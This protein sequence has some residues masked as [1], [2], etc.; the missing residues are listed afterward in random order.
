M[1]LV[2]R[3][4]K[5]QER[6]THRELLRQRGYYYQLYANQFREEQMRASWE[7]AAGEA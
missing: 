6:G 5:I 7:L 2:I 3:N 4:G 1:I